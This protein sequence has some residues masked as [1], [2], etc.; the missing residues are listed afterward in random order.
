V[1]DLTKQPLFN[2]IAAT[3]RDARKSVKATVNSTI[4]ISYWNIGKLNVE[5]EQSG[6]NR[7]EYGQAVLKELAQKLTHE[8]GK[9][10]DERNLRYFHLFYTLFSKNGPQCVPN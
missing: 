5:D 8:F 6:E 9:G 7:A 2:S 10:F 1:N 4:V 3:I